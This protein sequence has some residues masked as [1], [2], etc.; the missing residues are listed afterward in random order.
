MTR[1][2]YFLSSEEHD[3]ASLLHQAELAERAGFSALWVS[4]H[5][6]PWNHAQGQ[7]PFVWSVLGALAERVSL[8]ITT[9]VT[10][11]TVRIHPAVIAQASAT[12]A[13]MMPGRFTLGI[14]SGEALNEC[15][16]GDAWPEAD[17]RLEMLE[18]AVEVIRALHTGEVISHRGRH[19]TTQHAKIFTLP[20]TLP[21][22][23]ISAF[24]PKSLELAGRI[25]DG[26]ITTKPDAEAIQAFRDAGG[27]G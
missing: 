15:V 5:F 4:D 24:G 11:P 21:E 19:Y 23:F 10:C 3:V 1:F 12:V 13:A 14:G 6:H 17:V 22:I 25:G 7:S 9:A 27:T 18:E 16:L 2:G 20:E 8:P 26:F